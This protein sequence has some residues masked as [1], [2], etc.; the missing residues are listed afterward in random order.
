MLVG[1]NGGISSYDYDD[2]VTLQLRRGTP[3]VV[4]V[5]EPTPGRRGAIDYMI[6]RIRR[7]LPIDGPLAPELC[8]IG[9]RMIDTALASARSK[10]TQLL[11]A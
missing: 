2:H 7:D 6:E 1:R 8:L 4:P 9:Q 5:D 10:R 3:E 11:L